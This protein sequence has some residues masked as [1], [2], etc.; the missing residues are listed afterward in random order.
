MHLHIHQLIKDFDV[1]KTKSDVGHH[2]IYFP[3]RF[4]RSLHIYFT[5][6][7]NVPVLIV[8]IINSHVLFTLLRPIY[9]YKNFIVAVLNKFG[10]DLAESG[11]DWDCMEPIEYSG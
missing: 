6:I 2:Q 8:I 7:S 10:V 4:S 3:L 5:Y 1:W 9:L 11:R